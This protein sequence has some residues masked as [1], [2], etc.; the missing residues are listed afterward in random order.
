MC[1]FAYDMLLGFF[2]WH[3]NTTNKLVD[4]K[5][6]CP[7]SSNIYLSR[8]GSVLAVMCCQYNRH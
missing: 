8:R 3:N 6:A 7:Q 4:A 1:F 5:H 2:I